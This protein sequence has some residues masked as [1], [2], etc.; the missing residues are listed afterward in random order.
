MTDYVK[1]QCLLLIKE[2]CC[3]PSGHVSSSSSSWVYT[4]QAA[5]WMAIHLSS[6]CWPNYSKLGAGP[7][8]KVV[9]NGLRNGFELSL[10]SCLGPKSEQ[11]GGPWPYVNRAQ[12]QRWKMDAAKF[13]WE[14]HRGGGGVL[15]KKEGRKKIIHTAGPSD[16]QPPP[17]WLILIS[18][19][20]KCICVTQLL[21]TGI[22]HLQIFPLS[23]KRFIIEGVQVTSPFSLPNVKI[24]DTKN[25]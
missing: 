8:T 17:S 15:G 22:L 14:T 1:K 21:N 7:A 20:Q 9:T 6:V 5:V 12:R 4:M 13:F 19:E 25:P 3:R 10:K 23:D 16:P 2:V 11:G 24:N 18:Q